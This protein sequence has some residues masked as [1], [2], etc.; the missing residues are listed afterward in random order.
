VSI[1]AHRLSTVRKLADEIV[2]LDETG[3]VEQGSHSELLEVDGWYAEMARLP[4]RGAPRLPP[5][6]KLRNPHGV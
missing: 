5:R 3:I 6:S 4:G 1:I 2:V